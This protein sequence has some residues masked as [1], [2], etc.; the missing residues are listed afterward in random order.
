MSCFIL[1]KGSSAEC[2]HV[3]WLAPTALGRVK[4]GQK[5]SGT[6]GWGIAVLSEL[7]VQVHP[8]P[9]SLTWARK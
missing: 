8:F 4:R 1:L 2:G 6:R 7:A 5:S 3:L 9:I